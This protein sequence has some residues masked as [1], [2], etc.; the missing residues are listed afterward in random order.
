MFILSA[1]D[2]CLSFGTD[3]ILDRIS[4]GVGE[5][6]KIG[7][8]G[9]NGA[10]KSMLLKMLAGRIS[11]TSGEVFLAA[12]KTLGFLEQDTGLESDKTIYE[13][14][15]G[16]FPAL[17]EAESIWHCLWNSSATLRLMPKRT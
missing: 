14:M 4:L 1:S 8:V 2:L 5:N 6:D 12:G 15:L 3:I 10:G 11:P 7:I 13:E 17:V 16:A 9:V